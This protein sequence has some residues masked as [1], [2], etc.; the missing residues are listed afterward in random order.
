MKHYLSFFFFLMSFAV[1]GQAHQV[2]GVVSDS[3]GEKLVGVTVMIK[4]S[5]AATSTDLNGQ[6]SINVPNNKSTLV[7]SYIGFTNLEREVGN[8]TNLSIVMV[9]NL[10]ALNEVVVVGY[11]TQKKVNLTGAVQSVD[12]RDAGTRT[13]TSA[14]MALQGK[15]PGLSVT[16]AS[17]QPGFS[18]AEIRIRGASSIANNNDPLVIIDGVESEMRDVNPKDIESISVLKDAS[19]AAI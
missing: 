9:E 19:S 13:F 14:E 7:L 4:E 5:K 17:G 3:N 10:S 12:V 16:S 6:F 1:F 11:G 15:V 18:Q 2:S 8:N